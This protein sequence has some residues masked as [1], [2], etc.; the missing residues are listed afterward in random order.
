MSLFNAI[1]VVAARTPHCLL[2]DLIIG[3]TFSIGATHLSVKESACA[4]PAVQ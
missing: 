2:K 4:V 3:Q 1:S